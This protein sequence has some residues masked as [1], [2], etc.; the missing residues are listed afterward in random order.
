MTAKSQLYRI[1]EVQRELSLGKEKYGEMVPQYEAIIA[2]LS[3][4]DKKD[5]FP[6]ETIEQFEKDLGDIKK[7]LENIDYRLSL[8]D[9]LQKQIDQG[10]EQRQIVDFFVSATLTILGIGLSDPE[11]SSE[12]KE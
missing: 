9:E 4:S 12:Q 5:Q 6:K 3:E 1:Y 8:I 7:G 10:D 11:E 2:A